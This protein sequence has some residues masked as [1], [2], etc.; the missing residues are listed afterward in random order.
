MAEVPDDVRD[1]VDRAAAREADIELIAELFAADPEPD[2]PLG[3]AA[4]PVSPPPAGLSEREVELLDF[5]RQWWKQPGSKEQAVRDRFAMSSTRYYQLV[6][7]LVE[8]EAAL[9]HDP[10]LVKRLRR[11]RAQRLRTRTARRLGMQ[12]R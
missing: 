6:N 5:E 4:A 3:T 11:A 8:R 10:M 12:E 1:A 9:R 7:A 2:D